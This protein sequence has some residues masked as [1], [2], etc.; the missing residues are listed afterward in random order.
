LSDKTNVDRIQ[1]Y[2]GLSQNDAYDEAVAIE[3]L[4]NFIFPKTAYTT[5][6]DDE[7]NPSIIVENTT[8]I[9]N[10]RAIKRNLSGWLFS[11]DEELERLGDIRGFNSKLF[12]EINNNS[13]EKLLNLSIKDYLEGIETSSLSSLLV[14]GEDIEVDE[15][16]KG[17]AFLEE[18][19]KKIGDGQYLNPNITLRDIRNQTPDSKYFYKFAP[20]EIDDPIVQEL[21]EEMKEDE[22]TFVEPTPKRDKFKS[23]GI[24]KE[25]FINKWGS[26]INRPSEIKAYI[27]YTKKYVED[28][29][30]G[31]KGFEKYNLNFEETVGEF[32]QQ[33]HR[34]IIDDNIQL[35]R[36]TE[37]ELQEN[38]LFSELTLDDLIAKAVA[39]S[40]TRRPHAEE[41]LMDYRLL[42]AFTADPAYDKEVKEPLEKIKTQF[43]RLLDNIRDSEQA[44]IEE[45]LEASTEK[46][47]K[48]SAKYF[49]ELQEGMREDKGFLNWSPS[50]ETDKDVDDFLQMIEGIEIHN[51]NVE[52]YKYKTDKG[53]LKKVPGHKEIDNIISRYLEKVIN[54]LSSLLGGIEFQTVGVEKK[55]VDDDEFAIKV[56]SGTA[57][58]SQQKLTELLEKNN[59]NFG[60]LTG[61]KSEGEVKTALK[62]IIAEKGKQSDIKKITIAPTSDTLLKLTF[63][64]KPILLDLTKASPIPSKAKSDISNIKVGANKSTV[65]SRFEVK[66]YR[67][68][69]PK[70]DE[71][72]LTEQQIFSDKIDLSVNSLIDLENQLA[73]IGVLA[74]NDPTVILD[75][76]D[77]P[78]LVDTLNAIIDDEEN[79]SEMTVNDE[80]LPDAIS[81]IVETLSD[82]IDIEML[83]DTINKLLRV[84]NTVL[85]VYENIEE[86]ENKNNEDEE[87][88]S[89][90]EGSGIQGITQN[91]PEYM[92]SD[93]KR[94]TDKSNP[95]SLAFIQ[96]G[97]QEED[98]QEAIQ[99]D[100]DEEI[101]ELTELITSAKFLKFASDEDD[102]QAK[103]TQSIQEL[104]NQDGLPASS[105]VRNT[106]KNLSRLQ[107]TFKK[108]YNV[109]LDDYDRVYEFT[110]NVNLLAIIRDFILR[111]TK[112]S[113]T[114]ISDLS[115][116]MDITYVKNYGKSDDY[117]K[118]DGVLDYTSIKK[119]ETTVGSYDFQ[120]RTIGIKPVSRKFI[121][122]QQ[123]LIRPRGSRKGQIED[124]FKAK[125]YNELYVNI[126]ELEALL[127]EADQ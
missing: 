79:L 11:H 101:Q 110:K 29:F 81:S 115:V 48:E 5:T 99:N 76:S 70:D 43:R 40:I 46:E 75:E 49:A 44:T 93:L 104:V 80:K 85:S 42:Y 108:K 37:K 2:D 36:V 12:D 18:L 122:T 91:I 72:K 34:S 124:K 82:E 13:F 127:G 19:E 96:N 51:A 3:V 111:N 121:P 63:Q 64:L 92:L 78:Q 114:N 15:R 47:R 71:T 62:D 58:I 59:K 118:V 98:L 7:V 26:V 95:M 45:Q 69:A 33:L 32:L 106:H 109:S 4:S 23:L 65:S 8:T 100:L 123:N 61:N 31:K 77:I 86:Q 30:G 113:I 94:E 17:K 52:K 126:I 38:P 102:L 119:L 116:N 74:S 105:L 35:Y 83:K 41:T 50:F 6:I 54:K 117:I 87:F 28:Y 88:V 68:T 73:K 14:N 89:D 120:P 27:D 10:I 16:L 53:E 66:D 97:L 1:G 103:Y 25:E 90:E 112:Y 84:A 67:G 107:R 20:T 125:I 55:E 56:I 24:N 9:S 22:E 39:I 21:L 60:M 57:P